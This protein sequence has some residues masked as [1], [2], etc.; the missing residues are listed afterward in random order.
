MDDLIEKRN[1]KNKIII[2]MQSLPFDVLQCVFRQINSPIDLLRI[3]RVNKDF[4]TLS[5]ANI[6]WVNQRE[7]ILDKFPSLLPLFVKYENVKKIVNGK[8]IKL[9]KR[10]KHTENWVVPKGSWYVFARVL[11]FR[12]LSQ[13][14]SRKA[15]REYM[16][17][18]LCISALRPNSVI[19]IVQR[20]HIKLRTSRFQR[21]ICLRNFTFIWI[22]MGKGE[23]TVSIFSERTKL[24]IIDAHLLT[25]NFKAFIKNVNLINPAFVY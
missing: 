12:N 10:H 8:Q 16:L 7:R 11:L 17:N 9:Q 20:N 18:V 6:S 19:D 3:A 13:V 25:N 23:S 15:S 14:L 22:G 2:L 24:R 5:R 4:Y 21:C 1:N